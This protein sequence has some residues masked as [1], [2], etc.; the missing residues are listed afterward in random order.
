MGAN[1]S[2]VDIK[3]LERDI[4]RSGKDLENLV[5]CYS[6]AQTVAEAVDILLDLRDVDDRG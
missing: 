2:K 6:E 1:I 4:E 3:A 5:I